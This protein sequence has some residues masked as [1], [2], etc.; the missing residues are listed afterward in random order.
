MIP[1]FLKHYSHKEKIIFSNSFHKACYTKKLQTI[2]VFLQAPFVNTFIAFTKNCTCR[3]EQKRLIRRLV[4][5]RIMLSVTSYRLP[6]SSKPGT[7]NQQLFPNVLFKG[8]DVPRC[9]IRVRTVKSH[10]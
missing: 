3:I 4:R 8:I 10:W 1:P 9:G 6:V 7:S 5:D 2:L